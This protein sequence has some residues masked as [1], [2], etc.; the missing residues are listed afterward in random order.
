MAVWDTKVSEG[1]YDTPGYENPLDKDS[2]SW[3]G[4]FDWEGGSKGINWKSGF[5]ID[6]S[7]LFESLFNKSKKTDKYLSRAERNGNPWG[8]GVR[9]GDSTQG[10]GTQLLE[11][12]SALYPQQHAPMFIPG[13]KAEP[14]IA[15][16]I[17]R[18]AIGGTIGFA[19]GGPIGALAGGSN[20]WFS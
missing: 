17:A 20:P 13:E 10:R 16:K 19:A 2:P 7:G 9:F 11:N 5:G 8:S 12:L 15:E 3:S 6:K 14:S 1:F 4:N 18:S